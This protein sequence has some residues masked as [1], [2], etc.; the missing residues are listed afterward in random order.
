VTQP[1]HL[2]A[3]H[4][5]IGGGM[6]GLAAAYELAK[7]GHRV[8]VLEA[9]ATLGGL[10]GSFDVEGVSLERFYHH[11]FKSDVHILGLIADIGQADRIVFRSTR[12]GLYFA[13]TFYRLSSPLD[14]LRFTALNPVDRI[15][16][17]LLALR[18]KAV[19]N[20][21]T[22]EKVTAKEWLIQ[23]AGKEVYRVVWEPLLIGKFGR[24]SDKISAV[25]FW[26]KIAL[27]GGSRG[28]GGAETLAYYRGGFGA[29]VEALRSEIERLGG[30]IV[31]NSPVT[32]LTLA[33]GKVTSVETAAQSY[34]ASV[35]VA[36]PALPNIADL[37]E[38]HVSLQ[39]LAQLRQI[40]YLANVCLV[41]ELDRSLSDT[42][43]L[44]VNDATFPFVGIIEH[45]N[46]EP[47]SSYNGRHI[48]YLS[49]YLPDDDALYA[50]NAEELLAFALPHLQ[51]MFPKFERT[52]VLKAHAWR[53]RYAQPIVERDYASLIP[54][55]QTSL[56]NCFIC[57][58]AQIY[59]EDRGTN[60]AV[61]EGRR[62]GK[63]L[64]ANSKS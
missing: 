1:T 53:A 55:E 5:I 64:A 61:R 13:N 60:Y 6:T 50:M 48:A 10:A 56:K 35:V 23:L 4:V 47:A 62:I 33:Q 8:T 38:P 3:P 21:R 63:A 44:N 9:D 37:L 28:K 34:P 42:Y 49:K 51:R 20:W 30:E 40:K 46:F 43:W 14:L 31:T 15:R 32:G 19:K 22:L 25:W 59:P 57:S 45:T 36:T 27:R 7:A 11:W 12:T 29:L 16:L 54:T 52:W 26:N 24:W 18:V 39:E 41:L 58:M 17:G 2:C